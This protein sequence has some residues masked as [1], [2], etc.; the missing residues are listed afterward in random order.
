MN[1]PHDVNTD[2]EICPCMH[3]Y[4]QIHVRM[5]TQLYCTVY[6]QIINHV[7]GKI[8]SLNLGSPHAL[9]LEFPYLNIPHTKIPNVSILLSVSELSLFLLFSSHFFTSNFLLNQRQY[10][11]TMKHSQFIQSYICNADIYEVLY[12][13]KNQAPK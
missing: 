8:R 12:K 5:Q 10:H 13:I 6:F 1:Q 7:N 11:C 3:V 2:M 4:I 9:F